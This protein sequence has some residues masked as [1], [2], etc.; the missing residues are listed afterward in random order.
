MKLHA[1]AQYL[2]KRTNQMCLLLL[3]LHSVEI[4]IDRAKAHQIHTLAHSK[5]QTIKTAFGGAMKRLSCK[6]HLWH[7]GVNFCTVL[8][9]TPVKFKP[10]FGW[11]KTIAIAIAFQGAHLCGALRSVWYE[12]SDLCTLFELAESNN[13]LKNSHWTL[14]IINWNSGNK[15][16]S[17]GNFLPLASSSHYYRSYAFGFAMSTLQCRY[18]YLSNLFSI[19]CNCIGRSSMLGCYVYL[20]AQIV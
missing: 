11:I 18:R 6:Q 3:L 14:F 4:H 8:Q 19:P 10:I 2:N 12:L 15:N 1:G 16:P 7:S 17:D 13:C 20:F 9:A 5:C